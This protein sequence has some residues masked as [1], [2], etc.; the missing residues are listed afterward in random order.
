MRERLHL[1]FIACLGRGPLVVQ[2]VNEIDV[3]GD[4]ISGV[5][6]FAE[7]DFDPFYLLFIEF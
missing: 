5:R 4:F 2:T 1:V 6:I 3:F 7:L